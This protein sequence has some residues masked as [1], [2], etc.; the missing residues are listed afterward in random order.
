MCPRKMIECAEMHIYDLFTGIYYLGVRQIWIERMMTM[1]PNY[2][3]PEILEVKV[4][5]NDVLTDSPITTPGVNFP[6]TT[7]NKI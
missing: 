5:E 6:K 4:A 7:D 3:A 1:K 2:V